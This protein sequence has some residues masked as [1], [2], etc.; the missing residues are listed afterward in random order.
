MRI[1]YFADGPWSHRAMEKLLANK[2]I[3][4]VFV[5]ARHDLQDPILKEIAGDFG[6]PFFSHPN[7]NENYFLEKIISYRCDLLVSMSFNQ[8]FQKNI[9]EIPPL[10]I[11]N[12]HAGK[13]PFYRGRNILNWVLI[14]DEKEFGKKPSQLNLAT[15]IV[16]KHNLRW[17]A[18]TIIKEFTATELQKKRC[19]YSAKLEETN[20]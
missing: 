12:C 2:T 13:L 17:S 14:N 15:L 19:D 6:L 8:I 7:V 16:K 3:E 5:C 11:I 18:G 9:V 4:I 20:E 10:G 1:G